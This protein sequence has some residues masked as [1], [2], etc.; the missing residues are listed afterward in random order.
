MKILVVGFEPVA[1]ESFSPTLEAVKS[2]PIMVEN[3]FIVKLGI[4][5]LYQKSID[6]VIT[7]IQE[8]NPEAVVLIGERSGNTGLSPEFAALNYID[9]TEADSAG[10][11]P[12]NKAVNPSGPAAYITSLP[13]NGMVNL[14]R[15]AGVPADVSYSAGITLNNS[16]MYG[17]AHF[18]KCSRMEIIAGFVHVPL[19]PAQS[20][21]S[22][23]NI[24]SM[25]VDDIRKGVQVSLS[26][27]SIYLEKLL[28]K[29][30]SP[31]RIVN[32]TKDSDRP[33]M[34]FGFY[35]SE[36]HHGVPVKS[37]K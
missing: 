13:I 20:A 3:S 28:S 4:P 19:T 18:I 24:P 37:M 31:I 36:S 26:A 9:A 2:L 17:V 12:Q 11:R 25:S 16:V 32:S 8:H 27:V 15:K 7:A 23:S 6:A 1:G 30:E 34:K 22:G 10:N 35:T 29:K 5:R 14:M 21:S 33:A